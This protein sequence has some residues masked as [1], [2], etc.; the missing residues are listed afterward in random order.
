MAASR[1]QSTCRRALLVKAVLTDGVLSA[2]TCTSAGRG[3]WAWF[4]YMQSWEKQA[5][6][7]NVRALHAV[8]VVVQSLRLRFGASSRLSGHRGAI[9]SEE[10]EQALPQPN[11]SCHAAAEREKPNAF[12][13]S[14]GAEPRHLRP[15]GLVRLFC[16]A[17]WCS[18]FVKFVMAQAR[19]GEGRPC[20]L[21]VCASLL[22]RVVR[23]PT[24]CT[25]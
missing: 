25:L 12:Y 11:A 9:L 19:R 18:F 16:C 10:P 2:A 17:A 24:R 20:L 14:A 23:A 3:L 13:S 22:V 21:T 7:S 15:R 5:G 8:I 1:L 6:Q 4:C